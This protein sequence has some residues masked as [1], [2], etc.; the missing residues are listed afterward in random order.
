MTI[1][2]SA[3]MLLLSATPEKHMK[4]ET[5]PEVVRTKVHEKYPHAK[6]IDAE[7]ETTHDRKTV[8]EVKLSVAGAVTELSFTAE[9]NLVSEE[10]TV[11][12]KS[13]PDEIQKAFAASA[14]KDLKIERVEEVT[15]GETVTWE[16]AGKGT[17]GK[18]VEV[19]IDRKG[20]V[21]VK[22]ATE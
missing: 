3:L 17:D 4:F 7:L 14:A 11:P 18:R 20:T 6:V 5:L 2:L 12:W 21:V 15:E 1:A 13:V 22:A 10:R 16:L 9:G 8:Y 19:V